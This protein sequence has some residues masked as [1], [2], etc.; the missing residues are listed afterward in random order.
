ML[1]QMIA[2]AVFVFVG[3]AGE[4]VLHHGFPGDF[5]EDLVQGSVGEV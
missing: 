3:N 4:G 2:D 5:T 1:L